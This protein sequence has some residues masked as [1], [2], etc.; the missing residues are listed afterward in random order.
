MLAETEGKPCRSQA[1]LC[2]LHYRDDGIMRRKSLTSSVAGFT[3]LEVILVV[4]MLGILS[5]IAVAHFSDVLQRA[6]YGVMLRKIVADVRYARDLAMTGGQGT[7]VHIDVLSNKYYLRWASGAYVQNP[8]GGGDFVVALGKNE[9][10]AAEITGTSFSGGR[11]DFSTGGI[12]S[13]AGAA[14]SGRLRLLT[15][16]EAKRIMVTANTGLLQ[17]ED[18]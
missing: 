9:F 14:F 13:N 1:S 15:L 11:L 12:P 3:L 7:Q 4:V 17:F 8:V 10:G 5:Y 6:Q 2:V 18:E 16:N